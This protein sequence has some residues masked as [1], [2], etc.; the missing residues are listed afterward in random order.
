VGLDLSKSVKIQ[1][2]LLAN[3]SR[4]DRVVKAAKRDKKLAA[5]LTQYATGSIG[6]NEF[7]RAAII[8]VLPFYI[9][10]KM[11]KIV[12]VGQSANGDLKS[13]LNKPHAGKSELPK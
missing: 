4:I 11:K 12:G 10:Y 6:Y 8:K 5:L 7:K 3:P 9:W 1:D 13:T 2:Y